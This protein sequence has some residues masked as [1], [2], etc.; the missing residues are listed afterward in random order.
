MRATRITVPVI[1]PM[2]I[3]AS[4]AM[5]IIF[6]HIALT[7]STNRTGFCYWRSTGRSCPDRRENTALHQ[8]PRNSDTGR[9]ADKDGAAVYLPVSMR[10][11]M[12]PA[13]FPRSR[14]K[15]L[16]LA[17]LSQTAILSNQLM[18]CQRQV[19]GWAVRLFGQNLVGAASWNGA[20][21]A[22]APLFSS[23]CRN[24]RSRL[25]WSQL[26]GL[27]SIDWDKWVC[28]LEKYLVPCTSLT[29]LPTASSK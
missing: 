7:G 18:A 13:G 23:Q 16:R 6:F 12:R 26:I 25:C 24:S 14:P 1:Q 15:P 5:D 4:E 22:K 29:Q 10:L 8:N 17:R 2:P 20:A 11:S 3:K 9:T 28:Q 21:Y 27:V 19:F